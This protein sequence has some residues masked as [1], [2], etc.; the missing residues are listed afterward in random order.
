MFPE[1]KDL[2][3]ADL[4][5][6]LI[7]V[8]SCDLHNS[9]KSKDDEFLMVSIAGVLGNNSIGYRHNLTKVTRAIRNSSGR[10]LG[11]VFLKRHH[12]AVK[13][14]NNEFIRV[15]WGTPNY[16]R[17]VRSFEHV[18]LGVY[19]HH[20][21]QTFHG[22]LTVLMGN[23]HYADNN[24]K[25]FTR[26]IK[27]GVEI[28]LRGRDKLGS[29]PNVFHYQFTNPDTHGI[30]LLKMCFY[31]GV[32]IFVSFVPDGTVVPDDLVMKLIEGGIRTEIPLEDKVYEFNKR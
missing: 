24:S 5:Q 15:I 11:E 13:L 14:P 19:F 8:P 6:Q 12:A 30:F 1:A 20:F 32:D 29:N 4:R 27:H 10:L 25:V 3:G 31:E 16:D 2:A 17:L 23:L 22:R 28:E 21:G 26:W 18:A 9:G 7:T